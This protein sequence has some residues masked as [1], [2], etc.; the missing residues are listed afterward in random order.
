[1][2][3]SFLPRRLPFHLTVPETSLWY[4]L[5]VSAT[6][7]PNGP[8]LTFGG[9]TTNYREFRVQ[10]EAIAGYLQKECGIRRGD[11]VALFMHNCP[12][13]VIAYYGI[14]RAD[15]V[16]VPVN[17]MNTTDEL[18]QLL[19]DAG[20]TT[21]I[22]AQE[23]Q[24]RVDPLSGS[25]VRRSIVACYAD[26]AGDS[27]GDAAAS[28]LPEA[29]AA[30]RK[31]FSQ[32]QVAHWHEVL[33]NAIA[34]A[35]H[36]AGPDDLALICY[37]SGTTG[38]PKGCVH[39][40]RGVMHSSVAI[41]HWHDVRQHG[42]ALVVLPLFHVTG[43]QNSMN[44]HV[45]AGSRMVLMPRWNRE[46]AFAAIARHEV[47]TITTVP[48]MIVDLIS[49][50]D[51]ARHDL[52]SMR[53]IGGGGAAMPGAVAARLQE[54]CGLTYIEGYGM[55][56]T[57]APT[58]INPGDRPKP[59]CLGIPIFDTDAR[60]IDPQTLAELSQGEVGE[61]IVSGPQVLDEYWNKPDENAACFLVRDGRKFLR[62]G[63]LGRVDEDGYYHFVD[64]LKRMINAAGFK[65]WPAEVEALLYGHPGVQEACV[66][67][68]NDPRSGEL[69]KALVVPREAARAT[70]TAAELIAWSGERMAAY[71][72]PR[73]VEFVASLP[74]S[75]TGKI[76]WRLLQEQEAARS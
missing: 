7:F 13:F 62:T 73:E 29:L 18:E 65:V 26:Y 35:P 39:R 10:S 71:K 51:P 19:R 15:A 75:A 49:N 67:G 46:A 41:A 69:V 8:A 53:L 47:S 24:P 55:T 64:R 32:P 21:I 58:H 57:L 70:L 59:Q 9:S 22:T 63:D 27:G 56:E 66:I 44:T 11:R 76:D 45:Y 48:A 14:L 68:K 23:L 52:S 5:E 12:Q 36:T 16:V 72:V 74:K 37:T 20:A 1:M 31:Q 6:R 28:V 33:A 25:V 42:C 61:I 60:I 30:P 4:N 54:V 2:P 40:H 50:Y 17:C 34:P 3:K 43:M 38:K